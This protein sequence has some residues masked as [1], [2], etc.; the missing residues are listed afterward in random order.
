MFANAGINIEADIHELDFAK[1]QKVIDVNLTSVYLSDKYAIEQFQKQGTGGAIVNSGS[2]HSF[3]ARDGL[4]A[5]SASKGGV[6][7]L[8]QQIASRYS[9][10]GIRANAITPGYIE[11]PL[12][13]TLSQ[14]VIDSLV[15]LHPAGRLGKPIEVAKTVYSLQ[16]MMLHLSQE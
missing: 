12:M 2:I 4:T 16:V 5:Y 15:S 6:K 13:N 8:T 7:M 11:T 3:V 1:W 14:D 9:K 10:D